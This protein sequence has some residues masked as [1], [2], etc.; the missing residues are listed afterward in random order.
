[1]KQPDLEPIS[2]CRICGNQELVPILDLGN[3]SLTG[4]FPK[5]RESD[6]QTGPLILVKCFGEGPGICGLV[7]LQH[8]YDPDDLYSTNY[9][10]RSGLN[11]SMVDHLENLVREIET[12]L[13]LETDDIVL[14]IGSNDSTLLRS[15]SRPDIRPVGID[16]T[17][18]K[19]R[20]FYPKNITLIPQFFSKAVFQEHFGTEKAKI[21]TSIAMFYDLE[22]PISFV[23][24]IRDVLDENG[25]WVFEQSYLPS[26]L[27]MNAYDT[28]CHEHLE[29]YGLKQIKWILDQTG[30]KIVDVNFNQINGGSFRVTAAL[31]SSSYV[32][33]TTLVQRILSEEESKQL[34][35]LLPYSQFEKRVSRHKDEL[36]S[37]LEK[38]KMEGAQIAGYGASTKGNVLLQYCN[39]SSDELPWVADINPD[40]FGK[41]TPGTGI[42]I[43]SET[44]AKSMGTDHFLV[45][46]WHFKEN[47]LAREREFL[48]EG[49]HL[50]FP[51]PTVHVV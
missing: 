46:P 27:A 12:Q 40:K 15:F 35:T 20:E 2:L 36:R 37:L 28:V 10:Y 4:I 25:V 6:V 50:I 23:E 26:M 24:Q 1:M 9:G 30:L 17:G 22:T 11:N 43:V 7:Q 41:Y 19:F 14:D 49:K 16:P 21:I 38:L 18:E 29:Y 31:K 48:R 34:D 33:A 3:Q 8:S 47:I 51:L 32:E 39:I 45:L 42:P 5:E 13:D 44:Y